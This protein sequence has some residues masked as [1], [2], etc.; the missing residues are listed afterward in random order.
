MT[1]AVGHPALRLVRVKI[2]DFELDGLP[3]GTWREL[4]AE[5]RRRVFR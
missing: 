2:G 4:T 5:E 3:P 1:A